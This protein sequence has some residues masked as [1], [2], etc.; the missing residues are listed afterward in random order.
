VKLNV[1][2]HASLPVI[3]I[4]S[5]IIGHATT[6]SVKLAVGLVLSNLYV[7]LHVFVFIAK[8]VAHKYNFLSHSKLSVITVPFVYPVHDVVQCT[9][10]VQLYLA[11]H[12]LVSV[13]VNVIEISAFFHVVELLFA[14]ITGGILSYI[15]F[16][17]FD[18]VFPF[19]AKSFATHAPTF[20]LTAHCAVG[21]TVQL[22]VPPNPLP[23]PFPIV[24]SVNMKLYTGSLNVAV[25][26]NVVF[27]YAPTADVKLTV[28]THVSFIIV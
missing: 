12:T 10:L 8:S 4:V 17:V 28:G 26:V 21:V 22:Y 14:L 18:A 20:T 6:L 27:V 25:T 19:V 13:C 2:H 24:T 16:I 23:L 7:P 5:L 11:L 9:S 15:V 3:A 1:L